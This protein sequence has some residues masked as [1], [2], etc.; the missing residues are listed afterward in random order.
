LPP[1]TKASAW[2]AGEPGRDEFGEVF[3]EAAEEAAGVGMAAEREVGQLLPARDGRAGQALPFA[4]QP[5]GR[6][7]IVGD[8]VAERHMPELAVG[9][10]VV[11][12]G[13]GAS[14]MEERGAE[15][16]A[17]GDDHRAAEALGAAAEVLAEG[18]AGGIVVEDDRPG[19]GAECVAEG[20]AEVDAEALLVLVLVG[21]DAADAGRI[22]ERARDGEADAPDV[23]GGGLIGAGADSLFKDCQHGRGGKVGVE[24][25][26]ESA[27]RAQ[28]EG[29]VSTRSIVKWEPRRRS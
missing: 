28:L 2:E 5:T 21:G 18:E 1:I 11:A 26:A 12:A 13:L 16:G 17:E 10:H 4:G 7:V 9:R 19:G 24:R 6:K 20:L 3:A 27:L 22:V 25:G 29:L 8:A 15:A 23:A 14:L